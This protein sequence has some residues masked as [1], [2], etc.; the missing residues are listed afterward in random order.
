MR[1]VFAAD[2][3]GA[4]G[5]ANA[6]EVLPS[7]LRFRQSEQEGRRRGT[8]QVYG[9]EHKVTGQRFRAR[10]TVLAASVGKPGLGQD[11]TTQRA[12]LMRENEPLSRLVVSH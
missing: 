4:I 5:A 10:L 12:A 9:Q 8:G 6:I 7:R 11:M 1:C 3:P 2:T